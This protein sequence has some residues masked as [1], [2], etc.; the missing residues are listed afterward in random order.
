M[1]NDLAV[2][3][4]M[5]ANVTHVAVFKFPAGITLQKSIVNPQTDSDG[6]YLPGGKPQVE[7]LNYADR[8]KL[9]LDSIRPI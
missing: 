5:K 1:R 2:T 3:H 7:V 4:K 9:Q 6:T 8:S